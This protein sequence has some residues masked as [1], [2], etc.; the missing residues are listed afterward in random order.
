MQTGVLGPL[1]LSA[2]G[3]S[4][5]PRAPKPRQLLAFL[6]LNANRM[7]RSDECATELWGSAPPARAMSTVQ[8]HILHIRQA[9]RGAPGVS[10]ATKNQGYQLSV[11][12]LDWFTF[13]DLVRA[14]RSAAACADDGRAAELFAAALRLW[15][16]PA[17]ADVRVGPR[18]SARVVELEETRLVVLEQRVEADLRLGRHHR[19]VDE[20]RELSAAHPTHENL[21]AQLMIALYRGGRAPAALA[22]YERLRALL[23]DTLG[24]EPTPRLRCLRAA[25]V[26]GHP[27]LDLPS[28]RAYVAAGSLPDRGSRPGRTTRTP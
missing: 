25:V 23:A 21:H 8:S 15:R 11:G 7:V 14:G 13:G 2:N 6:L 17:L 1:L 24:I 4:F 12:A 10:L 5:V 26:S 16:G 22:V 18:C 27:V 3:K 20:L 28:A 9:L 19:L